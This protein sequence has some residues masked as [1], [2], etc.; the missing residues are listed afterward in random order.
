MPSES[1]FKKQVDLARDALKNFN[2]VKAFKSTVVARAAMIELL[3][4]TVAFNN[5]IPFFLKD[6]A[7]Q[8]LPMAVHTVLEEYSS[9]NPHFVM[10]A[11]FSKVV[12]LNTRVKDFILK[13]SKGMLTFGF[14]FSSIKSL[15]SSL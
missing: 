4:S 9:N 14:K 1:S 6:P 7:F 13:G 11:S 2:T 12:A 15:N 5:F 3:D 10:P 8:E